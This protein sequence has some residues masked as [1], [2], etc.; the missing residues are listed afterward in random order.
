[1]RASCFRGLE[2]LEYRGLFIPG[3]QMGT[4]RCQKKEEKGEMGRKV[5]RERSEKQR[6]RDERER[7]T[8]AS[9]QGT[10]VG[11]GT[12]E[13]RP[14]PQRNKIRAASVVGREW[15]SRS[16]EPSRSCPVYISHFP[17]RVAK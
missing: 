8:L 2:P 3:V 4:E 15:H 16:P 14:L 9:G 12:L 1:M 11:W 10:H 6:P 5:G 13:A 7:G 17:T